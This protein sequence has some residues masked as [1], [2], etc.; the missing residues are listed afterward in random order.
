MKFLKA[1]LAIICGFI[2]GNLVNMS[3]IMLSGH[4]I[5]PPV[6]VDVT[7][8]EGLK[9]AIHL[10]E[11]KH[12]LF[13]F[14]A[15][16]LGTMSGAFISTKLAPKSGWVPAMTIGALF[17][18][19]GVISARMI[20]APAWFITSDLLLAYFP[21]AWFGYLLAKGRKSNK[22]TSSQQ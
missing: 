10:F 8:T 13:P 17:L 11:P 15:H 9:S 19:G 12:F 21:F 6:G 5:P 22:A 16:A 4:V 20:P 1:L 14:L 2:I 18:L 3:V 7:T